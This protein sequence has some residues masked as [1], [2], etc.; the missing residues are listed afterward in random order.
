[1]WYLLKEDVTDELRIINDT[2][3]T[4]KKFNKEWL[5]VYE[6]DGTYKDVVDGKL[7]EFNQY[8]IIKQSENLYD[9]IETGD[10]VKVT[11]LEGEERIIEINSSLPVKTHLHILEDYNQDIM[12]IYKQNKRKNYF[13]VWEKKV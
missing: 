9:L 7:V 11:N 13:I 2:E 3:H 8:Y 12:A 4:I 6:E 1:M 10:L 5:W